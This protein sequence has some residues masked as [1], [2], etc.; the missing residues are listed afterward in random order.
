MDGQLVASGPVDPPRRLLR[1]L[2]WIAQSDWS[3]DQLFAGSI[4]NV[5]IWDRALLNSE[6][7]T[8]T[9]D[10]LSGMVGLCQAAVPLIINVSAATAPA[11]SRNLFGF[12]LVRERERGGGGGKKL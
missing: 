12:N 8:T 11:M 6:W 5:S 3:A 2:N 10:P 4:A 1:T 7:N 9:G